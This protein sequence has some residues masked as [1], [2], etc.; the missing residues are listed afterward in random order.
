MACNATKRSAQDRLGAIWGAIYT[1]FDTQPPV[2]EAKGCV[3]FRRLRAIAPTVRL[4][5]QRSTESFDDSLTSL[6]DPPFFSS[7]FVKP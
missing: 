4:A 3:R 2:F 5:C 6:G 1:Y 7:H